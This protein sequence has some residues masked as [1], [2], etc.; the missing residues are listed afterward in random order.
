MTQHAHLDPSAFFL[1]G[2]QTGVLLIHGYTGSP[3]EMRWIGDYLHARGLTVSGPLLPGHGKTPEAMNRCRWTEWTG[4]VEAA[5]ADLRARCMRVF[6]GGLSMG[7]LLTLYLAARHPD[8]S[9]VLVYSPAVW[10]ATSKIYLTPLA[11]HFVAFQHKGG[12]SDLADPQAERQLWC[13]DVYPVAAAAELLKLI[14][15]VRRSLPKIV[16]PVII[17]HSTRDAAIHPDSARRTF[18]RIGSQDKQLITLHESGHC[19]TVDAE[20]K[21]VAERSYDFIVGHGG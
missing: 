2:G 20:W 10:T 13:Y 5:L 3:T 15:D 6:V 19:I 12:D 11:R 8:L 16:C 18:E 17:M 9:G 4:H 21:N 7:S 1:E 14:L